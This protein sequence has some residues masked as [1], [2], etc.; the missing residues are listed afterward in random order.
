MNSRTSSAHLRTRG[1]AAS[2][3]CRANYPFS[4]VFVV[5]G[6]VAGVELD[7]SGPSTYVWHP[8]L[9][10]VWRCFSM[11]PVLS[12]AKVHLE[13]IPLQCC[14]AFKDV[15]GVGS[16]A[17]ERRVAR[18]TIRIHQSFVGNGFIPV[19][20]LRILFSPLH[21]AWVCK[22][23]VVKLL[24]VATFRWSCAQLLMMAAATSMLSRS[25]ASASFI[26]IA[27]CNFTFLL[28]RKRVLIG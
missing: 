3:R 14:S 27:S 17:A 10:S 21:L 28:R 18:I 1:V 22:G 12:G 16:P 5:R 24:P 11:G 20:A 9:R 6:A 19:F 7:S 15:R 26:C 13:F 8:D 2:M 25:R 4:H 23:A